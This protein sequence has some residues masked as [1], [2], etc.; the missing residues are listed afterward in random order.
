MWTMRLLLKGGCRGTCDCC[1]I[2]RCY[3]TP[4]TMAGTGVNTPEQDIRLQQ[5]STSQKWGKIESTSRPWM[6]KVR[7]MCVHV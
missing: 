2:M 3:I 5:E 4:T 6:T 7:P 1:S